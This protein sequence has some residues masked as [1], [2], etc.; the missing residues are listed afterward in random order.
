MN[1]TCL[2]IGKTKES[3]YVS[4]HQHYLQKL[5]HYCQ[6]N[7]LE[8]PSH[9]NANKLN[10]EQL[11][12]EEGKIIL[13]IIPDKAH[14][15]LLDETGK[16]YHSK[17]FA[18][19]LKKKSLNATTELYFIIGGAYGF[20][21]SVYHR[22]QEKMALSKMTFTHQMVRLIFLEQLYRAFSIIKGEKYH[23]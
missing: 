13:S 23:H 17:E 20:S 12:E 21:S 22:A 11:K 8:I 5:K 19:D 10:T 6:I 4:F 7:Y 15:I 1:I 16:N 9:K 2:A 3:A 18:E 14:V